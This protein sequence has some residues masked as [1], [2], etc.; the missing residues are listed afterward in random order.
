M[1]NYLY[2]LKINFK[3]I[4]L[5]NKAFFFF[6]MMLPIAFYI[7]YTKVLTNGL[8]PQQLKIWNKDYLI[9]MMIYGCV[10]GSIITTA[11]ILLNDQTSKFNLFINLKPISKTRYYSSMAIIFISLNLIA[12]I[13]ISLV[14]IFVNKIDLP[15][16][17]IFKI[18]LAN[19]IGTIPLI[20]IG[21]MISLAKR[22]ELVNLLTNLIVFPMAI[23]S[24]LWWP[25]SM[26]PKW[27]Q[28]FGK[29]LP[30]YQLSVI[31]KTLI[32]QNIINSTAFLN[33]TVWFGLL[34]LLL[35]ILTKLKVNKGITR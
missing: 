19:T 4:I 2:Q 10:L 14:G 15:F 28:S 25:L 3:R 22:T 30:T 32:N 18:I 23:I 29:C 12:S 8:T 21:I 24:G 35:L 5:R 27:L 26:M 9:S 34:T 6:D 13:T 31:N 20:M 16:Y 33:I 11:N 1:T 7:L 17:T